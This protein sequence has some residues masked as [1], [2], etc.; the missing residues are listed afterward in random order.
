VK[1]R[2]RIGEESRFWAKVNKAG[3]LPEH[4]PELG[5]CWLWTSAVDFG[6]YPILWV[7]EGRSVRAHRFA[8]GLLKG[9]I[10]DGLTLDHLCRVRHCVNPDHLD[11][12]TAGENARRSPLAPY[13]VKARATHC[14]RG[15]AF[16]AKNTALHHGRRECR[17]CTAA[18]ARVKRA[19]AK[20]TCP[21]A[22]KHRK[23]SPPKLPGVE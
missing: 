11:P 17:A 4:R 10:P 13:N 20:Q 16:D 5:P 12:C 21:N 9:P 6:N 23:P 19:R 1:P 14:H 8:Y 18:Q 15:H 3:P 2:R 7:G 22:A